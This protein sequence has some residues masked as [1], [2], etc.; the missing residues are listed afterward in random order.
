MES[1]PTPLLGKDIWKKSLLVGSGTVANKPL[2][3]Q[4]TT[5]GSS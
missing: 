2:E 5:L 3:V 4:V 1:P